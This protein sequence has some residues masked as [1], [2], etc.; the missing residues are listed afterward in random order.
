MKFIRFVVISLLVLFII[1][2]SISLF[3]PSHV[4]I[5][6]A[7]NIKTACDSIWAPIDNFKRWKDWNS[8]ISNSPAVIVSSDTVIKAG[9]V[10]IKW[11]SKYGKEHEAEMKSE[12]GR[13]VRNGF[14]CIDQRDS[15]TIQ[16]YMDFHLRWYPWEKF[17]SL[18]LE[19]TYGSRMEESLS[20][21]KKLLEK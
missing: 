5:S 14:L 11:L 10:T 15:I 16:W 1:I 7:I 13:T 4:R 19:K 12:A 18:M 8:F 6:K 9:S 21:L 2:T 20:N 17:G 3:I